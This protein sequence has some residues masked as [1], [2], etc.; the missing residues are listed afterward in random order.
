[1]STQQRTFKYRQILA[2]NDENIIVA[3]GYIAFNLQK[4]NI[5]LNRENKEVFV[6]METAQYII[7]AKPFDP[8]HEGGDLSSNLSS[9]S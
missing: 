3:I 1:M 2:E 6:T 5:E 7:S 4:E 8:P 9:G